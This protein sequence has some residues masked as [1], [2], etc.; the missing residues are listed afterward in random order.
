M[1]DIL[2]ASE[3]QKLGCAMV[4]NYKD[5]IPIL[6]KTERVQADRDEENHRET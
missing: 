2:G 1:L 4:A 6:L 3:K 5:P